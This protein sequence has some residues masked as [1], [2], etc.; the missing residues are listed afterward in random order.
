[1]KSKTMPLVFEGSVV[2]N[3][4]H[5]VKG[6]LSVNVLD[7]DKQITAPEAF[8]LKSFLQ[9]GTL[10]YN[11]RLWLDEQGNPIDV[12]KVTDATIVKLVPHKTDD[13]LWNIRDVKS[14]KIVDTFPKDRIPNRIS[15]DRGVFIRAKVTVEEVWKRVLR[16]MLNGFSWEGMAEIGYTVLGGLVKKF[17][18]KVDMY[19]ASLVLTPMQGDSMLVPISKAA[20]MKTIND[21]KSYAPYCFVFSPDQFTSESAVAWLKEHG[22]QSDE[23][24]L[25]SEDGE[26]VFL[27]IGVGMI[28][29]DSVRSLGIDE[30]VNV[31]V[32]KP[33]D[34]EVAENEK[35][36]ILL[37]TEKMLGCKVAVVSD[38]SV[39]DN[40]VEEEIPVKTRKEDLKA[41]MSKAAVDGAVADGQPAAESVPVVDPSS[42]AP[43]A[44]DSVKVEKPVEVPAAAP[45]VLPPAS[46]PSA[47]QDIPAAQSVAVSP[48]PVAPATVEAPS[49]PVQSDAR[50]P[51]VVALEKVLTDSAV[52]SRIASVLSQTVLGSLNSALT[53]LQDLMGKLTEAAT[54]NTEILAAQA[55]AIGEILTPTAAMSMAKAAVVE[56]EP[57]DDLIASLQKTVLELQASVQ[58]IRKTAV[59]EVVPSERHEKKAEVK[60]SPL[61][62]GFLGI[63]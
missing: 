2:Q 25:L 28:D 43:L 39:E 22:F 53:G 16:R 56:T 26:F 47:S 3:K 10:L 35:N 4:D 37:L 34:G 50:T 40:P 30:G 11:H 62:K 29:P 55:K 20:V 36:E 23:N 12:G 38:S 21:K 24:M 8:N 44:A 5:E 9:K 49:K 15:G 27:Q 51:E 18:S 14:G 46:E 63:Q 45:V 1:M 52:V 58:A 7:F 41:V 59:S 57:K 54:K 31:I 19:E 42:P 61:P 13:A 33:I 60:V 32:G 48:T 6:F 17:I